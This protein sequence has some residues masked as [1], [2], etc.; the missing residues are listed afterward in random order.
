MIR[1]L[2]SHVDDAEGGGD[3]VLREG[4]KGEIRLHGNVEREIVLEADMYKYLELGSVRR[5]TGGRDTSL[6]LVYR[7]SLTNIIH[8]Y[9]SPLF[10][11][12]S[13]E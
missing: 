5:C 2:I 9:G 6:S 8:L 12:Y 3:I 10:S 11:S 7:F 4:E 13:Y 1:D